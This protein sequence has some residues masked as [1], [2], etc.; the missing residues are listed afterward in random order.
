M[1]NGNR[2]QTKQFFSQEGRRLLIGKY[3][4]YKNTVK[5]RVESYHADGTV[6]LYDVEG[7]NR[8]NRAERLPLRDCQLIEQ[9]GVS[10][11]DSRSLP[12]GLDTIKYV[13][14]ISIDTDNPILVRDIENKIQYQQVEDQFNR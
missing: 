8:I 4:L 10:I 14:K 2:N 13:W 7:L 11:Y 3:V 6:C 5:C 9:Y 12:V 1:T